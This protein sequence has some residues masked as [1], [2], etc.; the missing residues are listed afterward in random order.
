MYLCDYY[1]AKVLPE[2]DRGTLVSDFKKWGCLHRIAK[3]PTETLNNKS[4][5]SD[6]DKYGLNR[7]SGENATESLIYLHEWLYTKRSSNIEGE[8]VYTY[9]YIKDLPTLLELENFNLSGNFD[10]ISSLSL[11]P[12]MLKVRQLK[13]LNDIKSVNNNRSLHAEIGLYG[14]RD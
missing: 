11:A 8:I 4:T 12:Y 6:T 1:N 10:R 14:Y 3:D 13:K 9:H 7:G 2:V 5:H